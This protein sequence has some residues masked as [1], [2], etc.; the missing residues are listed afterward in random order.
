M[1]RA[2]I[3]PRSEGFRR[4]IRWL[5]EQPGHSLAVVEAAAQRFDLSPQDEAFLIAHF[6]ER[7]RDRDR[8]NGA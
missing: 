3:L 5:S 2:G 4:A 6:V 7:G 1:N 8:R